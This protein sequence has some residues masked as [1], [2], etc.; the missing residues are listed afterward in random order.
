ML[1]YNGLFLELLFFFYYQFLCFLEGGVAVKGF[2]FRYS[3][4]F[5]LHLRLKQHLYV[6]LS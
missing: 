2:T 1:C 4:G 6:H 5:F 3:F